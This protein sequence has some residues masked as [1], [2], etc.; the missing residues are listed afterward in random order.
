MTELAVTHL[1]EL[2]GQQLG[3][4]ISHHITPKS[5]LRTIKRSLFDNALGAIT[6]VAHQHI[7]G[8]I[9]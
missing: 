1:V 4:D 8:L 6:R 5:N 7:V 9:G 2:A 3:A